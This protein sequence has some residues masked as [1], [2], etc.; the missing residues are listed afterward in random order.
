[1]NINPHSIPEKELVAI[2]L[3]I[4]LFFIIVAVALIIEKKLFRKS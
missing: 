1:L 3:Y 4:S 2:I